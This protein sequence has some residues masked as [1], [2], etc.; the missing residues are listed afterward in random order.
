MKTNVGLRRRCALSAGLCGLV[1]LLCALPA[2]GA[3]KIP[4]SAWQTGK[5]LNVSSESH[6]RV[7]GTINNG[8]GFVGTA[9]RVITHYTIENTQYIY[10]ADRTS[11]RHDKAL[12][13]TINAPVQFA[14]VGMDFYLRDDAGRVHK[15]AVVTKTLKA[16]N[17]DK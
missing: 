13:V 12:D 5:L 4:D 9:V 3:D 10:Q 8:S 11:R 1:L 6:S 15:L 14:V 16:D 17:Q 7:V 2:S